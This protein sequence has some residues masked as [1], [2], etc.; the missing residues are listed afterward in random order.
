M[1]VLCRPRTGE[2]NGHGGAIKS[3]LLALLLIGHAHAQEITIEDAL[4]AIVSVETGCVRVDIGHIRGRWSYGSGGEVSCF[5]IHPSVLAHLR[6][7]E[8]SARIHSD[9]VYAESVARLWFIHLL[10]KHGNYHDSF[11][12]WNGGDRGSHR[13]SAQDYAA[14][15]VAIATQYAKERP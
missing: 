1:G 7:S 5:Q 11:A 10:Q 2:R 13:R 15:A 4:S 14:R 9:P 6:L 8:K 12:A 3:T